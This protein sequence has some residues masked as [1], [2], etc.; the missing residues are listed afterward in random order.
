[1][2]GLKIALAASACA[3]AALG[4][5]ATA[6]AAPAGP[7]EELLYVGV[8]APAS[9]QPSPPDK[10]SMGEVILAPGANSGIHT[11]N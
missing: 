3:A 11:V 4:L 10:Q 1:M 6:G 7:C 9:E 2:P 5:A 8:C